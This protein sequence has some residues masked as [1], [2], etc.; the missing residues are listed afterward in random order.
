[1]DHKKSGE[2][3]RFLYLLI[4][5][6]SLVLIMLSSYLLLKSFTAQSTGL[7]EQTFFTRCENSISCW[8]IVL[9]LGAFIFLA[10]A[11]VY[12]FLG[13]Y[14]YKL[15]NDEPK[16]HPTINLKLQHIK[17]EEHHKRSG[18]IFLVALLLSIATIIFFYLK[19]F[20]SQEIIERIRIIFNTGLT[21]A[22]IDPEVGK[23]IFIAITVII[24]LLILRGLLKL[25]I[26][27][28]KRLEIKARKKRVKEL[29][30]NIKETGN[31]LE[32]KRCYFDV[33]AIEKGLPDEKKFG[34]KIDKVYHKTSERIEEARNK[35]K[36]KV[37]KRILKGLKKSKS[38]EESQKYLNY[39]NKLQ[40]SEELKYKYA[41]KVDKIKK[42]LYK[43][44]SH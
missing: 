11:Y 19:G 39:L 33:L 18:L 22:R 42:R 38:L 10:G 3:N 15:I 25:R 44:L 8:A 23:Y 2:V 31:I 43:R 37:L 41:K 35:V 6:I 24:L 7:G 14:L 28:E 27:K 34:K 21:Y 32:A 9:F 17:T 4:L 13:A 16:Y 36:I 29:L 20:F 1:M 5:I 40:L 26:P 30:R 12:F